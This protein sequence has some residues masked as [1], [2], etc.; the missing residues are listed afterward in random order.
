VN[1]Q[2]K[3]GES[4]TTR[5]HAYVVDD[6]GD[7]VEAA[8]A[9][10]NEPLR[11][12]GVPDVDSVET[13]DVYEVLDGYT[14]EYED[15]RS[16]GSADATTKTKRVHAND[17]WVWFG[18]EHHDDLSKPVTVQRY[19][20]IDSEDGEALLRLLAAYITEGSASTIETTESRFG[21]SIAESREEWLRDSRTTISDCL[22]TRL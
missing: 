9:D 21:A 18:H 22:K 3:F 8:P 20:D 12:P 6:D 11:I 17:E 13:I 5:D 16:V 15:G 4:T 10:I 19:I 2:H 14:R 1:L 7:F